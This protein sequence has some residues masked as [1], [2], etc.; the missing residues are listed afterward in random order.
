[1]ISRRLT[2]LMGGTLTVQSHPGAGSV[3]TVRLPAAAAVP[4]NT[5][6]PALETPALYRQRLVHYVEDNETNVEVMRGVLAQ[7][8]QITLQ[9]SA[10]GL[11]GLL[12]MRRCPP[13]LILATRGPWCRRS[14]TWTPTSRP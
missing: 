1:V 5:P 3:F 2:E 13:D 4:S 9:S 6:P 8:P 11:D 12:A 10:L 14:A 7:R